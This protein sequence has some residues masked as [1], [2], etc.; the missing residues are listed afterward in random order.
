[1]LRVA[2]EHGGEAPGDT[3]AALLVAGPL[4]HGRTYDGFVHT[5]QVAPTILEALGIRSS[6]LRAVKMEGTRPLPSLPF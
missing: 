4:G 2:A 6:E 1:V 5:T 3:G